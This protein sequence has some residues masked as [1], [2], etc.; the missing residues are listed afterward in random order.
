MK[1]E[2]IVIDSGAYS[3][4]KADVEFIKTHIQKFTDNVSRSS[5]S[6]DEWLTPAEARELLGIKRTKYFKMK[7]E[8]A[9]VFTQFGRKA[10]ISRKSLDAFL[11]GNIV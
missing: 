1:T 2:M 4:L 9:F 7:S 11:K 10:K 8:G 3:Q 6:S 5:K